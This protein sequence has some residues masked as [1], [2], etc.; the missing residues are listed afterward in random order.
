M[1]GRSAGDISRLMVLEISN[2][3]SEPDCQDPVE[4][5][6]L[7]ARLNARG[8]E[9]PRLVWRPPSGRSGDWFAAFDVDVLAPGEF[10]ERGGG[11][12]PQAGGV[13]RRPGG[14]LDATRC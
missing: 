5:S 11:V 14:L 9:R 6:R 8:Q 10:G 4:L 12:G 3:I 13:L 7:L 2:R 1:C